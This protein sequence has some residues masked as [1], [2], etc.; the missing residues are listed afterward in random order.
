MSIGKNIAK[1]RKA[2]NLTQTELGEML[3]VSNQAVSKWESEMTMPDVMLLP[4]I[5]SVLGVE[6]QA[7]YD[8]S[9]NAADS[10]AE[11][12]LSKKDRRILNIS[13]QDKTI[14]ANVRIPVAALQTALKSGLD[15]E[16]TK[17]LAP[18]LDF[19]ENGLDIDADMPDGHA[20]VKVEEYENEAVHG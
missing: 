14:N 8:S 11:C 7:L 13:Y 20:I 9:E 3:S 17:E 4:E 5:A 19:L 18:F 2:K 16:E 12:N 6:I 1:Y 10:C 15:E